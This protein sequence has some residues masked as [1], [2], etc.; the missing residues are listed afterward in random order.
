MAAPTRFLAFLGFAATISST[1]GKFPSRETRMLGPTRIFGVSAEVSASG[2]AIADRAPATPARIAEIRVFI[3]TSFR[4]SLAR[5]RRSPG[6]ILRLL[7]PGPFARLAEHFRFDRDEAPEPLQPV[8][9]DSSEP[10]QAEPD[11]L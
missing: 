8:E 10:F 6:S 4:A 1:W 5:V 11:Q 9:L 3:V 2:N 7:V